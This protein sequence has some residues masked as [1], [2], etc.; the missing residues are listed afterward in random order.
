M[1]TR[2]MCDRCKQEYNKVVRFKNKI[3]CK[4]CFIREG[5]T[6]PPIP[7]EIEPFTHQSQ[8]TL[9]LTERQYNFLKKRIKKLHMSKS[10]YMRELVNQDMLH[11]DFDEEEDE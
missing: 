4:R 9:L 8:A 7:I 6:I 5:H 1:K 11:N 10:Q 2:K 3:L